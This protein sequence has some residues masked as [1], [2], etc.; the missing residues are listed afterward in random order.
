MH[1]HKESV[2]FS[3]YLIKEIILNSFV[4]TR[5]R[6]VCG[7][8]F[9]INRFKPKYIRNMVKEYIAEDE[10]ICCSKA[11]INELNERISSAWSRDRSEGIKS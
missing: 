11:S 5:S 2:S 9:S 10:H 3:L 6:S 4:K 8:Y 1:E 7:N